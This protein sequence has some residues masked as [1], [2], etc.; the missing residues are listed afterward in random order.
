MQTKV[1]EKD[2]ELV[3]QYGEGILLARTYQVAGEIGD[4]WN[5]LATE[6]NRTDLLPQ[7]KVIGEAINVLRH[8]ISGGEA[9][10]EEFEV[11]L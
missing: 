1:V 4:L 7:L 2:G 9:A 3:N 10:P 8:Q 6:M 5:R 11:R